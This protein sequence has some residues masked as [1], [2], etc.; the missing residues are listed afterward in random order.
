MFATVY[1]VTIGI[2]GRSATY[3]L[4]G[5]DR[6]VGLVYSRIHNFVQRDS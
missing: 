5:R 2:F 3:R 1:K 4:R 6:S